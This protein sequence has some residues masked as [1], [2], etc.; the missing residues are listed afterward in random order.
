MKPLFLSVAASF[1]LV[2]IVGC[3]GPSE[4]KQ[5]DHF[6]SGIITRVEAHGDDLEIEF[7]DGR[8]CLFEKY[9][10]NTLIE[11]NLGKSHRIYHNAGSNEV[12]KMEVVDTDLELA[13]TDETETI[14]DVIKGFEE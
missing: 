7:E 6:T 13:T 2:V 1:I 5:A 12:Y 11:Y 4:P 10:R 3:D 14:E 8:I 9:R